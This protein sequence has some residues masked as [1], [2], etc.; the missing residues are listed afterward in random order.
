MESFTNRISTGNLFMGTSE[1]WKLSLKIYKSIKTLRFGTRMW[2]MI[3]S[4]ATRTVCL[5]QKSGKSQ[6]RNV[7]LLTPSP[8]KKKIVFEMICYVAYYSAI[9]FTFPIEQPPNKAAKC[10]SMRP[11]KLKLK[12][13]LGCCSNI[14][15]TISYI[16]V[17]VFILII[18]KLTELRPFKYHGHHVSLWCWSLICN[19][20]KCY[21]LRSSFGMYNIERQLRYLHLLTRHCPCNLLPE[22]TSPKHE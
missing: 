12:P 13:T 6:S 5:E 14:A 17:F 7:T 9:K 22:P 3:S 21:P 16:S 11:W 15:I 1:T 4:P 8:S 10:G 20:E 19:L 18:P 2:N